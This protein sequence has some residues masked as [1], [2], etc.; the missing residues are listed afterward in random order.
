MPSPGSGGL[1]HHILSLQREKY[2]SRYNDALDEVTSAS[3]A[4]TEMAPLLAA[5]HSNLRVLADSLYGRVRTLV[6]KRHG[7]VVRAV[8]NAALL[9]PVWRLFRRVAVLGKIGIGIAL[10]ILWGYLFQAFAAGDFVTVVLILG[11]VIA[12]GFFIERHLV[13]KAPLAKLKKSAAEFK[14]L[15]LSYVYAEQQ[16]EVIQGQSALRGARILS[17]D[18]Q[19]IAHEDAFEAS[20][21]SGAFVLGVGSLASFRL[22]PSGSGS[23]MTAA[24]NN[25]FM[26]D[27]APLLTEVITDLGTFGENTLPPLAQYGQ[28]LWAKQRAANQLPQLEALVRDIDRIEKVWESTY[29]SDEVFQFLFR[30][31]DMF[32]MRDAATPPGLILCGRPENGKTHLAQKIAETISARLEK[33]TPGRIRTPEQIADLWA[34]SRG[35]DPVVLF[36][37]NV[38]TLFPKVDG[39]K[40]TDT[41]LEWIAEWEKHEP[42]ASRV[43][44]VMTAKT[45]DAVDPAIVAHVGRDSTIEIE[46]PDAAGLRLL[47]RIACRQY[48]VSAP[49]GDDVIKTMGGIVIQDV[50][51]I[52][53]AA[54]RAASPGQPQESHWKQA[55]Q[56]VRGAN[57]RIKDETK[58]WDRLILPPK[59]KEQLQLACK[60]LQDAQDSKQ[61]GLDVPKILLYGPPGT[62]KTEIARTIANEA[63]VTFMEGSLAKMKGGHIGESGQ[64]VTALFAD[65]RAAAPTVLFLDEIDAV[66][67][68]RGSDKGDSF[69]EDIVQ[70]LLTELEGVSKSDRPVFILA[71]TNHH[72]VMDEAILRRFRRKIEI[73][74]P[75]ES[76]RRE[77]LK[78]LFKDEQKSASVDFD[79]DEMATVV[80]RRTD[81][82]AGSF[83]RDLVKKA[84]EE[85]ELVAQKASPPEPIRLTR[86]LVMEEVERLRREGS[87]GVDPT[88]TWDTLV[89]SDDTMT[90]LRALSDGV[91]HMETFQRQGIEP[92]RAAVLWGP[93]GTGKTQ[94]AKTLANE[95]GVRF[96][97]KGPSD[98]G[99]TADS[100]RALF[101]EARK[102]A[103]CILFI[104]EFEAAGKSRESGGNVE[105]VT[106]LLRQLQGAKKE[107]R[108]IL[109]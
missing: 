83:L 100:V 8:I 106:E 4:L 25:D 108:P 85:A 62:G 27:H 34:A 37:P 91:R 54:K 2:Q 11:A 63:G 42:R 12:T 98:L 51:K 77:I 105:V 7:G 58:T 69:T 18:K 68:E 50:R 57:A 14:T 75:D 93:P 65:A 99:Q 76:G 86:E 59:I 72:E 103:P 87:D 78:G 73:P 101:N 20:V 80:A 90:Q 16:P 104:D 41:A 74:K 64:M 39:T 89:V 43:W 94:I 6:V 10:Y 22:Q 52:V 5:A 56:T 24:Q 26:R 23:L 46:G 102:I 9:K 97:L 109:Y 53:A 92:P 66:T 107:A 28:G 1:K 19:P 33:V 38:E 29:V 45:L 40:S 61:K 81:G 32:N 44:V 71:A 13:L 17:T 30:S 35:T 70:V 47:L 36:V 82:Q 48:D 79:I 88:A 60:V 3:M 55:I 49:P 96:L 21:G 31:I 67:K 95:G 15:R 84:I